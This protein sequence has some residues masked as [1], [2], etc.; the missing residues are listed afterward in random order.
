MRQWLVDLRKQKKLSQADV[1]KAVHISQPSYYNIEKGRNNPRPATA[2]KI[3]DYIGCDW[4]AF[5]EVIE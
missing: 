1:A 2:K 3:A 4:T 5:F